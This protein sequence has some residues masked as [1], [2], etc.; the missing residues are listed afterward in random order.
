MLHTVFQFVH[1]G[2]SSFPRFYTFSKYADI[3]HCFQSCST[4]FL[5]LFFGQVCGR[6]ARLPDI[7]NNERDQTNKIVS[8]KEKKHS[9]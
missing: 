9:R 6:D 3:L 2:K 1:I 5:Q 4:V 7:V 8:K